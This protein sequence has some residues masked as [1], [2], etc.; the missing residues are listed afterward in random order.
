MHGLV[1]RTLLPQTGC[2]F[3]MYTWTLL[4][5]SRIQ[6]WCIRWCNH[7]LDTTLVRR[8]Y[9]PFCYYFEFVGIPGRKKKKPQCCTK[10][11]IIIPNKEALGVS[12]PLFCPIDTPIPQCDKCLRCLVLMTTSQ[13]CVNPNWTKW[14]AKSSEFRC[15]CLV[16]LLLPSLER[17]IEVC[18]L[19][20]VYFK[21]IGLHK[22]YVGIPIHF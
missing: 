15:A 2:P 1:E 22:K 13:S 6:T 8:W 18:L 9:C 10:L 11:L 19:L 4:E 21:D 3:N 7:A 12:S 5:M 17:F 14:K 20:T 16:C